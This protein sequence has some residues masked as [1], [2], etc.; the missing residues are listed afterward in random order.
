MTPDVDIATAFCQPYWEA[1]CGVR[2]EPGSISTDGPFRRV[3]AAAIQ[4]GLEP[5]ARLALASGYWARRE[6]ARAY[7]AMKRVLLL[8]RL[9][10]RGEAFHALGAVLFD[11]GDYEG[12][13]EAFQEATGC[14]GYRNGRESALAA[15]ACLVRLGRLDDAVRLVD[16]AAHLQ[17]RWPTGR[18]GL[19]AAQLLL[20]HER[21]DAAALA[22][23]LALG[24]RCGK[25]AYRASLLEARAR[26]GLGDAPAALRCLEEARHVS[27]AAPHGRAWTLTG[28]VHSQIGNDEAARMAYHRALH[29]SDREELAEA[30]AR[31]GYHYVAREAY[32]EALPYLRAAL[33]L[34]P[35]DDIPHQY[36]YHYGFALCRL[37]RPGDALAPLARAAAAP[38]DC[39]GPHDP[40]YL[41]GVASYDAG[42]LK[43][44]ESWLA[45]CLESDCERMPRDV[46]QRV[47]ASALMDQGRCSE[48]LR[49]L[50]DI[51]RS[52]RD[53]NPA[54]TGAL[55]VRALRLAGRPHVAAQMAKRQA[56][57]DRPSTFAVTEH[58][59]ARR[60]LGD[61]NEARALAQSILA[62]ND[63]PAWYRDQAAQV[64]CETGTSSAHRTRTSE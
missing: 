32:I 17:G 41:L 25:T 8:P 2:G 44:A 53:T 45:Q 50:Q 42:C 36:W 28:F 46:A 33:Q 54:R 21:W 24:A 29:S 15:A 34:A 51:G 47:L 61:L 35:G 27:E 63:I 18:S 23:R 52:G 4:A 9:Q 48:A 16:R 49:R 31:L 39:A 1:R 55:M 14:Q 62:R 40:R 20:D 7:R 43:Q 3:A 56:R 19:H 10:A 57:R 13:Y 6:P 12:G 38:D 11:L 30:C 26:W 37:G 22:S 59:L 5:E 64:M 60:D 58:M